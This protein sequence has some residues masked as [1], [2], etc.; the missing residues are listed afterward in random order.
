MISRKM[1][2]F[3]NAE[4][5][6]SSLIGVTII[7]IFLTFMAIIYHSVEITIVASII[8]LL[9]LVIFFVGHL[10]AFTKVEI[11][12]CS[13]KWILFNKSVQELNWDRVESVQKKHINLTQCISLNSNQTNRDK[14]YFSI[15]KKKISKLIEIC[16]LEKVVNML[17][18][19]KL[20]Y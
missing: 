12:N 9:C 10:G 4:F 14:F 1:T 13:I 15:S 2:I 11:D 19:V 3:K 6:V 18:N 17:A 7:E 16:P 8:A 5:I 20:F